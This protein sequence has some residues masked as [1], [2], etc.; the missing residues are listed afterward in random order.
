MKQISV[1][2]AKDTLPALIR[3]V[4]DGERVTITRNGKPVVDVILHERKGGID[5]EGFRKWKEENGIDQMV[6]P[7]PDDFDDPLPWDFL[8]TQSL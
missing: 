8:F 7:I 5:F 6:G 1:K 3:A 4:E 2:E